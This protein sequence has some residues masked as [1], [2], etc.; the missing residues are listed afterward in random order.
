MFD[1][2]TLAELLIR[3]VPSGHVGYWVNDD[4]DVV[5]VIRDRHWAKEILKQINLMRVLMD[6]EPIAE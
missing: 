4:G 6:D 1:Q 3:L 2:R 5:V